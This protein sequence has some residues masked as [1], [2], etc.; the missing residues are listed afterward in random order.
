MKT[1]LIEKALSAAVRDVAVP[2]PGEG[3]VRLR[4]EYV[5]IC[6]SD[7][8]YYYEGANGAFVVR[9]PLV[10]GHELSGRVDLDPSGVLAAGTAVTVHPARF[11]SPREGIEHAPHLW[12]GGSY[13]GSAS[14]WPHTQGAASEY[15]IVE[16]GMVRV[17]PV[18]LPV[19]RAVLAEPL[20]V[21]LHALGKAGDVAGLDVLVTGSGPI[22]LMAV[23]A[24]VAAGARV[25][26]TDV[27]AGP[28]ERAT[29][30]GASATID[31]STQAVEPNSFAVVL[32]CSGV[33]VSISTALKSVRPGG[34]VVQVGMLPDDP[35]PV[36][37]APFISKE[38]RYLGAFRFLD[39]I[40]RAVELLARTPGIEAA[41]TH[42]FAVTDADEAFAT[43]RDSQRSG[44]VVFAL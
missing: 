43:A 32:E 27:L 1:L 23:A 12:P 41:L 9:E 17:L 22:G 10:P 30:L 3:E 28:L 38:V 7:L 18:E 4:V 16:A 20:A 42:E 36:N 11:G 40:D 34:T 39:E 5:G 44:K 2:E 37:L 33:P 25:T 19:R 24:A 31:V 15:L 21:A 29:A 13:L 6:G 8:H 26:A 35:R 14:T